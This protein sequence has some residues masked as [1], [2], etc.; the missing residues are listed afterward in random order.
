[1]I[2]ASA[3]G[4]WSGG[5]HAQAVLEA[6]KALEAMLHANP[7]LANLSGTKLVDQAF[8]ILTMADATTRT[9]RGVQEGLRNLAIGAFLAFRNPAAHQPEQIGADEAWEMLAVFSLLCR[10]IERYLSTSTHAAVRQG[11]IESSTQKH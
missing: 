6:A 1:M 2:R 4:L 7:N 3:E 11:A 8:S 10:R 9:G 5:H